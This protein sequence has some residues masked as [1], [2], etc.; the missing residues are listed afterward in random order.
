MHAYEIRIVQNGDVVSS[1]FGDGQSA[2]EA[3]E[4]ALESG[5][6]WAPSNG[7]DFSALVLNHS[8]L[9]FRFELSRAIQL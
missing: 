2:S 9:I 8:G 6:V 5:Q 1:G 3:L 4:N 7:S